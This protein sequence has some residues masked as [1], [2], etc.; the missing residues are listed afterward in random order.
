MQSHNSALRG[1]LGDVWDRKAAVCFQNW[2]S[3]LCLWPFLT[4]SGCLYSY[5][6]WLSSSCYTYITP[7]QDRS[8]TRTTLVQTRKKKCKHSCHV[9]GNLL[10]KWAQ[11]LSLTAVVDHLQGLFF[12]TDSPTV[13]MITMGHI[14]RVWM[15]WLG[16]MKLVPTGSCWPMS[17]TVNSNQPKLVSSLQNVPS[18]F[19]LYS[20]YHTLLI[21]LLNISNTELFAG[22]GCI[23]PSPYQQ[24]ILNFTVW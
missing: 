6:W 1:G 10:R 3:V 21:H 13:T 19:L 9:T 24:I 11:I 15:A 12:L 17:Q 20:T 14:W 2:W 4:L 23:I 16:I 5:T 18:H 22:I 8:L 7:N